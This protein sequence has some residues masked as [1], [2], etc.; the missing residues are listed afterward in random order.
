[1]MARWFRIEEQGTRLRTEVTAGVTTF[2][3]MAY[4]IFVQPAV[5]SS[6]PS[7]MPFDAV[8]GATCLAAALSTFLMGI[9]A[10]YPIALA[11]GMGENFFFV[12][13]LVPACAALNIPGIAPWRTALGVVAISSIPFLL[14]TLL[15]IR[16]AMVQALS[17][18][19]KSAAAV[20][21]GLFIAFIGL[22][23]GGVI[24]AAPGTMVRLEPHLTQVTTG[25]FFFGLLVTA[26]L[27][28]RGVRGAILLGILA[29]AVLAGMGGQI[30]WTRP[31]GPPP[32]IRPVFM[33]MDVVGVLQ[34]LGR[35]LPLIVMLSFMDIFDTVGTLVGVAQQA[36]FVRGPTIPRANRV[37]AAD[38]T[39]TLLGAAL[40]TSTVT[41]YIESTTGVQ[42]G[43][44]TGLAACVTGVLFL[45]ALF[46][47]PLVRMVT[48][49]QAVTAPALL[50][51]GAMM[52][53]SVRF[54]AWD[55]ATEAVPAFLTLIGIPLTY[56]IADGLALGFISYPAVKLLSGRGREASWLMYGMAAFLLLYFACIRR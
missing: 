54:I 22:Q 25:I 47:A 50:L 32:D 2:L 27:M 48:Q 51:V 21:I 29:S 49:C 8:M 45:L 10:N 6:E 53:S 37:M 26:V 4:I 11:P 31:V 36:G 15:G 40:G 56:S 24:T 34:H 38:A 7:G 19:M 13:T 9:L 39:G 28:A 17:P 16:Q 30:T 35:L 46:F 52:M 41:S 33:K 23:H 55:D 14:V 3:T 18:S 42:A 1:M 44:R 12:G 43:G 20:G 5:L